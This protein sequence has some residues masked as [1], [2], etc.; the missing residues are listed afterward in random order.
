MTSNIMVAIY[1]YGDQL[2]PSRVS[3][4]L[5]VSPTCCRKK[6]ELRSGKY[7]QKTGM[8]SLESKAESDALA[9]HIDELVNKLGEPEIPLDEIAMVDQGHLDICFLGPDDGE[10]RKTVE[11]TLSRKHISA[12]DRLGLSIEV[13]AY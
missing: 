10:E 12:I 3:E 1:L 7:K 11:F 5:G 2:E 13:T 6:G 9:D 4:V 8:W